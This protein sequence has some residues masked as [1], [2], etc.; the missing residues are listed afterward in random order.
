MASSTSES[1]KKERQGGRGGE[2]GEEQPA[3]SREVESAGRSGKEAAG[4]PIVRNSEDK[5][6]L[7][8]N[9]MLSIENAAVERLH[10]R[11]Q[12]CQIPE[13]N[14]MLIRHLEETREQ[15]DRLVA[16]IRNI[17]GRRGQTSSSFQALATPTDE[18]AGLPQYMPPGILADML[19]AS[20]TP[21]EQELKTIE[22][23]W[24]VENAE[25]M[26]YMTLVQMAQKMGFGD[27]MVSLMQSLDE[28]ERMAAWIRT[29]SP[30]MFGRYWG[31]LEAEWKQKSIAA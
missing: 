12:Q 29:N 8:L 24:L 13:V 22:I 20:L 14:D 2:G 23:D 31:Q 1:S 9:L 27:A 5:F 21:M 28:E 19:K 3:H 6:L 30:A 15:K 7:Y 16:I 18:R 25:V 17:G 10:A 4:A 26:G 11:I